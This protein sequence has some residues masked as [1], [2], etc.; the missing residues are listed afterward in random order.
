MNHFGD[1][2]V[3]GWII[4]PLKWSYFYI[5]VSERNDEEFPDGAIGSE[6]LSTENE[7]IFLLV[8]KRRITNKFSLTCN[9][10]KKKYEWGTK[11]KQYKV[12]FKYCETQKNSYIQCWQTNLVD[13]PK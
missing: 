8:M 5:I 3:H 13:E 9:N 1:V 6:I 7:I 4:F 11:I 12:N 2:K 10:L